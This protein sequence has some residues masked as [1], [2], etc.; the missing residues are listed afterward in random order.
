[1]AK[2]IR[3]NWRKWLYAAGAALEY[4]GRVAL[5]WGKTL[6]TASKAGRKGGWQGGAQPA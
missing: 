1:M 5:W 3:E 2:M 4:A 6:K